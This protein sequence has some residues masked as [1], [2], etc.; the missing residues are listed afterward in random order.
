MARR[1]G[2][3]APPGGL[4]ESGGGALAVALVV[5][6]LAH[7]DALVGADV[8]PA[9]EAI[10]GRVADPLWIER[11]A[12]PQPEAKAPTPEPGPDAPPAPG[13]EPA[14]PPGAARA[15]RAPSAA[16]E[17]EA[18]PGPP[19]V[20]DPVPGGGR[21]EGPARVGPPAPGSPD[22]YAPLPSKP[23]GTGLVY[24]MPGVLD[25]LAPKPAATA[26]VASAPDRL[27]AT[28][29]LSGTLTKADAKVG[30]DLPGA[31]GVAAAVADAVRGS[32]VP[33]DV[34]ATLEVRLDASGQVTGVKVGKT[35]GGDAG[36]WTKIAESAKAKLGAKKLD[37]KGEPAT[38]VVKIDSAMRFPSGSK[39]QGLVEPI[40]ANDILEQIAELLKV[41]QDVNGPGRGAD[42]AAT[43][44]GP[45]ADNVAKAEALKAK[46]CIPVGVKG[47]GDASD[48]GATA[49]KVV[50]AS[51][52][53][54]RDG[55]KAL[56]A[57]PI[58]PIDTRPGWT[59]PD[60]TRV[61]PDVKGPKPWWQKKRGEK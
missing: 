36:A 5:A 8:A 32:S 18:Q 19:A 9:P 59:P 38:I 11:E 22:E 47:A 30:L 15:A 16:E 34:K 54:V 41:P 23:A 37:V 42:G 57:G 46:F 56:P 44:P 1:T 61:R 28:K 29:A 33:A 21:G 24:T 55:V 51:Y 20:S 2:P 49:H 3:H 45:S 25:A 26:P 60:P 17:R 27:A 35:S 39:T 40:C 14:T 53:V 31:G 4:R 10:V 12:P 50:S 58:L 13:P 48:I 6:A 7:V 52:S 43:P